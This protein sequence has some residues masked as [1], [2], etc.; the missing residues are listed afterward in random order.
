MFLMGKIHQWLDMNK[1]DLNNLIKSGKL[2]NEQPYYGF[3]MMQ[4]E[5]HFYVV[6]P[7]EAAAEVEIYE[8]FHWDIDNKIT[9]RTSQT[10]MSRYK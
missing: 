3:A 7:K 10:R 9:S 2:Y 6:V 1:F 5:N 4:S 8:R